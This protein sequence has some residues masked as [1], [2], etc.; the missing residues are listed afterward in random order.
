MKNRLLLA[1]TFLIGPLFLFSQEYNKQYSVKATSF[2][3]SKLEFPSTPYQLTIKSLGEK[4]NKR[5]LVGVNLSSIYSGNAASNISLNLRFGKERF[6]DFGKDQKWRL[7]YGLDYLGSLRASLN[8]SWAVVNL[9]AG[10]APF[11]GLQYRI[12]KRLILYTETNYELIITGFVSNRRGSQYSLRNRV[13]PLGAI[14]LGFELFK[15]KK[16]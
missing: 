5:L 6:L 9:S 3:E 1:I 12:N 15:P 14:W 10:I 8:S 13:N 2:L 16:T 7:F 4:S 11:A